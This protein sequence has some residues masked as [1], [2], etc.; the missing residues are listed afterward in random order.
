MFLTGYAELI[1]SVGIFKAEHQKARPIPFQP[2]RVV[3]VKPWSVNYRCY[4]FAN[5][6]IFKGTPNSV[7]P[8]FVNSPPDQ[9]DWPFE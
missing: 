8:N 2:V 6:G 3:P 9:S 7:V 4:K 1:I 5:N